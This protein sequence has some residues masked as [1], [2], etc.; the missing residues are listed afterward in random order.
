[1]RAQFDALTH[2]TRDELL[3]LYKGKQ[4]YPSKHFFFAQLSASLS[5]RESVLF[6]WDRT[7]NTLVNPYNLKDDGKFK[8]GSYTLNAEVLSFHPSSAD[9]NNVW[10]KLDSNLQLTF[11]TKA[12]DHNGDLVTSITMAA[13][14]VASQ[15]LSG[16]DSK[17]LSPSS[18]NQ[19]TNFPPSEQI[20]IANGQVSLMIGL[21]GQKKR[22]FWDGLLSVFTAAS[23]SPILGLLPIPKLYGTAAQTITSLLNQVAQQEKLVQ[24]LNGKLLQFRLSDSGS[25]APFLL[26]EGYWVIM[27][28]NAAAPHIDRSTHNISDLILD[29]PGQLYELQDKDGN[30]VDMTYCVCNILL[31]AVTKS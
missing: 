26:K 12:A 14:D 8:S 31:P 5:T 6:Y 22:S 25:S 11:L 29:V 3:F 13:L 21:A 7:T 24:V 16:K 28:A 30:A 18:N 9:D 23:N 17:L 10:S 2:Y 15:F 1:M 4:L 27:D 20:V 19:L